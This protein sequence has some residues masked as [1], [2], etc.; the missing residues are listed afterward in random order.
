MSNAPKIGLPLAIS[1]AIAIQAFATAAVLALTPLAPIVAGALDV[2]PHVIGYQVSVVYLFATLISVFAGGLV[3]KYGP[4]RVSQLALL[5]GGLGLIG[6]AS[7]SIAVTLI[8]SMLIGSG[9]ALTNPAAS[10]LLNRLAPPEKR[11]LIFSLKQTGVPFGGML[12]GLGLPGVAIAF[13]WQIALL[14]AAG[15]VLGLMAALQAARPSWDAERD[16]KLALRANMLEG[17]RLVARRPGLRALSLMGFLFSAIQLSLVS[18][19]VVMLVEEFGWRPVEAGAAAAAVQASGAVGR[20]FWGLVA[21]RTRAGL[22]LLAGIGGLTTVAAASIP[23]VGTLAPWWLVI[24]LL[25]AFGAASIGWN[26]VMLAEAAR[27][28]PPGRVGPVAGGVL[29][30]TFLGVVVGPALFALGYELIGSY[31]NTYA[32]F[33][34]SPLLGSIVIWRGSRAE[35]KAASY[36]IADQQVRT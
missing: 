14:L 31:T 5:A 24:A 10:D 21:D 7:G 9:Y 17:L 33:A 2:S 23:L 35:R 12:A 28:S 22:P 26:G 3:R 34:L 36:A 11:N 15:L 6:L 18:F 30:L 16:P 1:T 8:A 29:M 13:G 27:L 25:C 20:V 19:A 4:A 32:I